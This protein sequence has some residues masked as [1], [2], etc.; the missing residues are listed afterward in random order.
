MDRVLGDWLEG[1][2]KYTNRSEPPTSYHLWTAISVI[3]GAL[4][5]KV[6]MTWH[7]GRLFPNF[8]V[9]LVGPSGKCRKS[10]ALSFGW[11]LL[12]KIQGIH[13]VPQLVTDKQLI[14]DLKDSMETFTNPHTQQTEF[15]SSMSVMAS[16]LVV[17]LGSSNLEFL[18]MLTSMYDSEDE[19]EYRTK[20]QGVDKI[21]GLCLNLLGGTTPDWMSTMLPQ[22]AIGGG[23]TSRCIFVV[24]R[25]RKEIIPDPTLTKFQKDMRK[26][27]LKDLEAINLLKGEMRFTDRALDKYEDWYRAYSAEPPFMSS[28]FDGYCSRR[29]AH[30]RKLAMVLS[31]SRGNDMMV[32]EGDFDRA[33]KILTT[34]EQTMPQ[35]FTG[36]GRAR[37]SDLNELVL[38][39]MVASGKT[40]FKHSELLRHFYNDLD[41]YTLGI[42]MQTLIEMRVVEPVLSMDGKADRRYKFKGAP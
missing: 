22:A 31:V 25:D 18:A 20:T 32:N 11:D 16:E 12:R 2:M 30:A 10:T 38:S 24:E 21:V 40:E 14:R 35:A 4:Q 6:Y 23:F 42:V 1:Y 15:H 27:L 36:L 37:Y 41:A 7:I 39:Y 26:K 19:W 8:F 9:I 5:R 28:N 34:T 13:T 33:L 17:F 3:A 29:A